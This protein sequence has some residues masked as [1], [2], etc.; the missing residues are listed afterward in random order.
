MTLV[1]R[2]RI[3]EMELWDRDA[4]EL[5][6]PGFFEFGTDGTGSFGFIAV[7]GWMDCRPVPSGGHPGLEFTWNGSDDGDPVS[8]RGTATL[9]DDGSLHGR[10]YFHLGDESGFRAEQDDAADHRRH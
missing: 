3:F 10:I 9:Q 1:G 6:G 2:W 7:E 8:G 4:I 5:M